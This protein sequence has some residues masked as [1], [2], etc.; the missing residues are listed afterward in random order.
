MVLGLASLKVGQLNDALMRTR[1][2]VE[3]AN[4]PLAA[5]VLAVILA[6]AYF[7]E[8]LQFGG[9]NGAMDQWGATP[10]LIFSGQTLPATEVP[11]WV[12]LITAHFL[13]SS[14]THLGGNVLVLVALGWGLERVLNH[15]KFVF[16]FLI[17][18]LAGLT[19]EC[20]LHSASTKPLC[21]ASIAVAA[22][23]MVWL[24]HSRTSLRSILPTQLGES[25]LR[26]VARLG[27]QVLVIG[28]AVTAAWEWFGYS[29]WAA[30]SGAGWR[31]FWSRSFIAHLFGTIAGGLLAG[32]FYLARV[33]HS[34]GAT[35][36]A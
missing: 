3:G 19:A 35:G 4:L 18:G 15:V 9:I 27:L 25:R 33:I 32:C 36:P 7:L 30:A 1:E 11:A 21:G 12:G 17:G 29:L 20:L 34:H 2:I 10:A 8:H 13:H 22:I 31:V 16:T 26:Q 14:L 28:V 6:T 23:W 24:L 5:L